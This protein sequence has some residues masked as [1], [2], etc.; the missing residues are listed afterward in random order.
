MTAGD[1]RRHRRLL[2][3]YPPAYRRERGPEILATLAEAAEAGHGYAPWRESA[4]LLVG[5]LRA[6]FGTTGAHPT[7]RLCALLLLVSACAQLGSPIVRLHLAGFAPPAPGDVTAWLPCGAV[8][9]AL[10]LAARGRPAPG[11]AA[12]TVSLAVTLVVAAQGSMPWPH[13]LTDPGLWATVL[14]IGCMVPLIGRR[15]PPSRRPWAWLIAVPIATVVVPT[16]VSSWLGLQPAAFAA[17]AA[18]LL[19]WLVVSP[20][21]TAAG[22]VLMLPTLL[23]ELVLLAAPSRWLLDAIVLAWLPYVGAAVLLASAGGFLAR[24]QSRL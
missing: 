14:A 2:R 15:T 16:P 17:L 8:A 1:D 9:A 11:V 3:L 5:G 19:L 12:A 7:L 23:S 21:L 22:A 10:V 4:G 6:R 13:R 18:G 20:R 24:T